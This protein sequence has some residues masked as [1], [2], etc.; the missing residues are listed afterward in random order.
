MTIDQV[1]SQLRNKR[2]AVKQAPAVT[3]NKPDVASIRH[4]ISDVKK[5]VGI[6]FEQAHKLGATQLAAKIRVLSQQ[7]AGLEADLTSVCGTE[8]RLVRLIYKFS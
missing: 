6:A 5:Q 2:P 8:R 1:N 4:R 7:L 3:N